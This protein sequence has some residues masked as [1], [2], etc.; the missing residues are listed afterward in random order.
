MERNNYKGYSYK[1]L[2][3]GDQIN[4]VL[5]EY[6][7]IS[8]KII[9]SKR[10]LLSNPKKYNHNYINSF[11]YNQPQIKHSPYVQ[12]KADD[13]YNPYSLY[14]N[15]NDNI[16]LN[17]NNETF[18]GRNDLIEEFKDT[19][20][21]SQIIKDDL[22][23]SCRNSTKRKYKSNTYKNKNKT[24]ISYKRNLMI[25]FN[26]GTLGTLQPRINK[27]PTNN[28]L[29]DSLN[30]DD[31]DGY[32][33]MNNSNGGIISDM[34]NGQIVNGGIY[35]I[36]KSFRKSNLKDFNN[37]N[38]NDFYK[39]DD[40][41]DNVKKNNKKKL[42]LTR[43]TIVKAYQ[44]IKK[45]NRILEVEINNYKRLANQYLNFGSNYNMNNNPFSQK[46]V[47]SFRQ[48]LQHNMQNNCRI[49]DL[50]LNIQKQNESLYNKIKSLKK[51]NNIIFQKIEQ[52]NRKNAEIQILN[53]ENEQKMFELEEKKNSLIEDLEK[54]K[55]L[56]MKLK[57]KEQN[58][59]ILN[60]SNKKA[61]HDNEEHIIKLKNTINQLN[62]YK[63]NNYNQVHFNNNLKLYQQKI[64]N[65]KLE[66]NNLIAK[67]QKILY[68]KDNLRKK[69]STLSLNSLG[70]YSE[71]QLSQ[72]LNI[73]KNENNKKK[74][75]VEEKENQIEALKNAIDTLS[76]QIKNNNPQEAIQKMNIMNLI[77]DIEMSDNNFKN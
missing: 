41:I 23:K 21:K 62:N 72:Q 37:N 26:Q 66:I 75:F 34:S 13:F 9:E 68:Y 39:N 45:E 20:E 70:F 3:L 56:L 36:N 63:N 4:E 51:K 30:D 24:P 6:N 18:Y 29:N 14:R 67:K 12:R 25:P 64:N 74:I 69:V 28:I 44:K 65:L 73:L 40:Y 22:L 57:N 59:N 54:N 10:D 17:R 5:N 7:S 60:E 52:K 47:N 32:D 8:K 19:L 33:S 77:N 27:Y 2:Q 49:I 48:S 35:N 71:K 61:L 16:S 53:E 50:I 1:N 11:H 43:D 55:I 76:N 31:D 58:L 42:E 15:F 46:A 38:Y